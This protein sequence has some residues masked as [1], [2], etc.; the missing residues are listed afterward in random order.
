MSAPAL[1][2]EGLSVGYKDKLKHGVHRALD[3]IVDGLGKVGVKPDH[4]TA[5]AQ[6]RAALQATLNGLSGRRRQALQLHL[7]GFTTNEIATVLVSNEEAT[8]RLLHRALEQLKVALRERGLEEI[9]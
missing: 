7:Q 5:R 9:E 2:Q 6:W 3:P 4:L 1:P 8:R